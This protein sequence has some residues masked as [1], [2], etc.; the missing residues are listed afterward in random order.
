MWAPKAGSA[1]ASGEEA[2]HAFLMRW[3]GTPTP[4]PART[5]AR[6]LTRADA[7][8]AAG[9]QDD[10]LHELWRAGDIG[11]A[12]AALLS[13]H[14]RRTA[15]QEAARAA[16]MGA[17][18]VEHRKDMFLAARALTAAGEAVSVLQLLRF[19]YG[20]FKQSDEYK[21]LSQAL[22][23][24]QAPRARAFA[25]RARPPRV[26]SQKEHPSPSQEEDG[27]DDFC[28]VCGL[29]GLLICCEDCSTVFHLFCVG[30]TKAIIP[31]PS[32]LPPRE[33]P[34][35]TTRSPRVRYR[36]V[37]GGAPSAARAAPRR[38]IR[39]GTPSA[40]GRLRSARRSVS[41]RRAAPAPHRCSPRTTADLG[42]S[43]RV[44]ATSRCSLFTS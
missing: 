40:T 38:T 4:S 19:F 13:N 29:R 8:A 10:A 42:K 41:R 23:A 33:C 20:Q 17:A 28:S 31:R 30:L 12:D 6:P 14:P 7:P 22:K 27:F 36:R 39:R 16:A 32:P 26:R 44:S 9:R 25:P 2:T 3:A 37:S 11:A 35:P 5:P 24:E 18:L 34:P 21:H 43:R 15:Q 1:G